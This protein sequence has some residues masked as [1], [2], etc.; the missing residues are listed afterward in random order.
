M[1]LFEWPKKIIADFNRWKVRVFG[2]GI[3]FLLKFQLCVLRE[4]ENG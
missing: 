3:Q 4:V 1:L 2:F